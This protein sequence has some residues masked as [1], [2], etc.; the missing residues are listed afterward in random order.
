[1]DSPSSIG[2]ICDCCLEY[3]LSFFDCRLT[4]W[5]S[6]EHTIQR[7]LYDWMRDSEVDSFVTEILIE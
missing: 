5:S 6:C 3:E 1:M 7:N 2:V 4:V